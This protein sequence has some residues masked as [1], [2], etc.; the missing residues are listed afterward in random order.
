MA[1]LASLC[2]TS[3]AS[4][5]GFIGARLSVFGR[6]RR[7][8]LA[9]G[10]AGAASVLFGLWATDLRGVVLRVL[11]RVNDYQ[12]VQPVVR[13]VMVQVVDMFVGI[14]EAADVLLHQVPVFHHVTA[15][16]VRARVLGLPNQDVPVLVHVP[17]FAALHS[18]AVVAGEELTTNG[19]KFAATAFAEGAFG[20]S[21]TGA[22]DSTFLI[23]GSR[24]S[25]LVSLDESRDRVARVHEFAAATFALPHVVRPSERQPSDLLA[26]PS[27][28]PQWL[29]FY[30]APA[31]TGLTSKRGKPATTA[32]TLHAAI[33]AGEGR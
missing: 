19:G 20:L 12:V 22:L 17:A 1:L 29:T 6:E 33:V 26:M 10:F 15:H 9:N 3:A 4:R 16:R 5:E 24:R 2:R 11:D 25:E 31:G 27:D 7:P 18:D 23:Y 30:P 21:Q 32:F 14:Q 8:V 28:E 13:T